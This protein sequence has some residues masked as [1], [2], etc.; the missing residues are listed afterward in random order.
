MVHLIL[1][2]YSSQN[3]SYTSRMC[4]SWTSWHVQDVLKT[5]PSCLGNLVSGVI[6]SQTSHSGRDVFEKWNHNGRLKNW[7]RSFEKNM[8]RSR[9]VLRSSKKNMR[10]PI[11]KI[12]EMLWEVLET[13]ET[14]S[15]SFKT[16]DTYMRGT[17]PASGARKDNYLVF[18]HYC[19]ERSTCN[20]NASVAI[21][22]VSFQHS[23]PAVPGDP[24][25]P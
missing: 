19:K 8:V 2:P 25:T 3:I 13:I 21:R 23:A 15:G 12:F 9:D 4:E 5:S 6:C 10:S 17:R 7:A 18:I 11:T 24:S 20:M 1:F 16:I 22:N 14:F